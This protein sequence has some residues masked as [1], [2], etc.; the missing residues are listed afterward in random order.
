M[1]QEV[2]RYDPLE[3]GVMIDY[4]DG[5]YVLYSDHIA[6]MAEL[7]AWKIELLNRN[8]LLQ[9]NLDKTVECLTSISKNSCCDQCQQAKLVA[10]KTLNELTQSEE[11]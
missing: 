11:K 8:E 1:S 5:D 3:S 10:L 9:A 2:K 4:H 6:A 7:E